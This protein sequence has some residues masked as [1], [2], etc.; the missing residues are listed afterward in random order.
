VYGWDGRRREEK[1]YGP[2]KINTGCEGR[3]GGKREEGYQN[4]TERQGR[5]EKRK[6]DERRE[7]R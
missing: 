1:K 2:H 5:I 4:N 7:K 3:N 6:E